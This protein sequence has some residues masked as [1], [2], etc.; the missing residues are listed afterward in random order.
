MSQWEFENTFTEEIFYSERECVESVSKYFDD[1]VEECLREFV[2]YEI[3]ITGLLT[4]LEEH[5]PA[6]YQCICDDA[7]DYIID[8]GV[9]AYQ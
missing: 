5:Y 4:F 1:N 7:E 9:L 3:G 8:K 2:E 6:A